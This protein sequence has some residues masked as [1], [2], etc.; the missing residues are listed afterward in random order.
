MRPYQ[1]LPLQIR[2][3]RV[4]MAMKMYPTLLGSPELEP[5]HQIQFIFITRM[6]F[7]GWSSQLG[8]LAVYCISHLQRVSGIKFSNWKF[9]FLIWVFSEQE[10]SSSVCVDGACTIASRLFNCSMK[11]LIISGTFKLIIVLNIVYRLLS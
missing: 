5:Q 1:V 7:G 11:L 4:V 8:I 9:A 3:G 10:N 2:M 6:P